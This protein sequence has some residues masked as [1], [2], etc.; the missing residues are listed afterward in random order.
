MIQ[1]YYYL[2]LDIINMNWADIPDDLQDSGYF[3]PE[4]S[5]N[6][7]PGQNISHKSTPLNFSSKL[8]SNVVKQA[9]TNKQNTTNIIQGNKEVTDTKKKR[10][11]G[12]NHCYTCKPRGKVLK[13]IITTD[14]D[15]GV[16]YHFDLH[17]RPIIL[18]TPIKHYENINSIPGPEILNIFKSIQI[19]C[20][21]W[22][23]TDYQISYNCGEWQT[24]PHFH[25]KI[26]TSE[27]LINRLR[28]DHF[29]RLKLQQNYD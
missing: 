19:F 2:L 1:F 15:N 21:H 23:I 29:L 4:K 24:H 22:N 11:R 26:K 28:R 20:S 7:V 16:V 25:I 12:K 27:K 8:Y 9:D 13:H 18:L 10:N 3:S 17:K 6:E 14:T 5:R